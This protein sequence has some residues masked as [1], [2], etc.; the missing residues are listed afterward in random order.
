MTTN[1][2]S[3]AALAAFAL[4]TSMVGVVGAVGLAPSSSAAGTIVFTSPGSISIPQLGNATPYPATIPVSGLT[5]PITDVDVT[6][7]GLTQDCLNDLAV[8]LVAPTGQKSLV[9]AHV[10]DSQCQQTGSEGDAVDGVQNVHLTFDDSAA[11]PV[12]DPAVSGTYKPTDGNPGSPIEF[13]P[14]APA[15]G[16][17]PATLSVFN[18]I[19]GNGAWSLFVRDVGGIADSAGGDAG[20]AGG[21]AGQISSGWTLSITTAS[22]VLDTTAPDTTITRRPTYRHPRHSRFKA[23]S[24][25]A[26]STFRCRVDGGPVQ[27]CGPKIDYIGLKKGK[28]TLVVYAVDAAGNADATPASATWKVWRRGTGHLPQ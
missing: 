8:L 3:V 20:M 17:Q 22:A 23:V 4:A 7:T 15:S 12:P 19:N 2:S 26:G 27:P 25:E 14:P 21:D 1:H 18:G 24:S 10:P 16:S 5:T 28:H 9:M 11:G 13:P 6:L